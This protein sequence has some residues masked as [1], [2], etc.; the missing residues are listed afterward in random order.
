[1]TINLSKN[2]TI[3]LEKSPGVGLTRVFM[4]LG[5]DVAQSKPSGGLM[6]RL[7]GGGGGEESIDLDASVIGYDANGREVDRVWF[8][9]LRGFNGAV[10]HSGDN[11]TGDGDGDDETIH[12]DL[13]RIPSDVKTLVFTVNSFIGQTFDKVANATCRLVDETNNTETARINLSAQ[14]SHTGVILA[15]L[16]RDGNG[17]VMK[18]LNTTCNGRTLDDIQG[19]IRRLI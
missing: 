5:W 11:R 3:R 4:G 7:F 9:E 16:T 1:M 8:R 12:V 6:S 14:G 19:D 17:W 13:T 18:A 2:E 15:S 10:N